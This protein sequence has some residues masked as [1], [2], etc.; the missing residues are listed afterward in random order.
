MDDCP[1][2]DDIEGAM[3]A[4]PYS[5]PLHFHHDGCPACVGIE[6]TKKHKDAQKAAK[7]MPVK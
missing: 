5:E 4:C 2:S 1:D 6:L 3:A 7:E